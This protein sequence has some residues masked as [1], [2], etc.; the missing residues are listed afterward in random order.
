MI[1][2]GS[3]CTFVTLII[4]AFASHSLSA[5]F[6]FQGFLLG[7]SQ[8]ISMPLILSFPAQ[9]FYKK[10]GMATGLA[11][12]GKTSQAAREVQARRRFHLLTLVLSSGS[13]IGGGIASLIMRALLPKIGYRN[14]MLVYAG[15]NGCSWLGAWFLLKSRLPPLAAGQRRVP[16]HWLPRGLWTSSTWWSWILCV[17]VGIFGYLVSAFVGEHLQSLAELFLCTERH[18]TTS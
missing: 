15:L 16:K 5:L 9:W 7:L 11:A 17:F 1:A 6:I 18:P 13:G 12:S 14:T 4:S 8:G 10:R 2:I 3:A